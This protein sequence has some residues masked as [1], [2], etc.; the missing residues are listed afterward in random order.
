[1]QLKRIVCEVEAVD[2]ILRPGKHWRLEVAAGETAVHRRF[3]DLEHAPDDAIARFASRYGL[4]R[5]NAA[6]AVQAHPEPVWLEQAHRM[7]Q[8]R[9]DDVEK[10]LAWVRNPTLPY[11]EEADDIL[12]LANTV[13]NAIPEADLRAM[14]AFV[15]DR[16]WDEVQPLL[17]AAR[18]AGEV[19]ALPLGELLR[20][21]DPES[22]RPVPSASLHAALEVAQR[23]GEK[24]ARDAR[25]EDRP[26]S[27]SFGQMLAGLLAAVSMPGDVLE[28]PESADEW[29]ALA[30]FVS[31]WLQL[32]DLLRRA[33]HE[34][35]EPDERRRLLELLR[36]RVDWAPLPGRQPA[37][38]AG[39]AEP[40]V[41]SRIEQALAFAGS[42]PPSSAGPTPLYGRIL[43]LLWRDLTDG[44]WPKRCGQPGCTSAVAAHRKNVFCATHAADRQRRRVARRR[45]GGTA[46]GATAGNLHR[47]TAQAGE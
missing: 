3:A 39:L 6:E 27:A 25:L 30:G 29:R 37:E 21:V 18:E 40:V 5:I 14:A 13:G 15:S 26:H 42:W 2:G 28:T 36:Q 24:L 45:A 8:A 19:P 17:D 10:A 9:E 12:K 23:F 33:A 35:L 47:R 1:M 4:L 46:P 20:P 38:I 41:R 7:G 44:R 11:P 22:A 31:E 16:P 43:L 32:V 34:G